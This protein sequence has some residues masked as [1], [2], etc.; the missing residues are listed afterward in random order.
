MPDE[1]ILT[2]IDTDV[3]ML[4]PTATDNGV[5][6]EDGAQPSE[7]EVEE[8]IA[9]LLAESEDEADEEDDTTDE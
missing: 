5:T 1:L 9:T 4:E 2:D 6:P 3:E 8:L 7:E